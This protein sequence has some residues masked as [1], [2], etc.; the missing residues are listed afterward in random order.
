[1]CDVYVCMPCSGHVDA[2]NVFVVVR[3]KRVDKRL[4]YNV[5][6]MLIC[7]LRECQGC[8]LPN[9]HVL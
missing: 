3:F 4:G 7:T 1:M 9:S 6:N 8:K 5:I 2:V